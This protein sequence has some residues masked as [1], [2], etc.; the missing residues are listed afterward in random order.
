MKSRRSFIKQASLL[1]AGSFFAPQ[2]LSSCA[3]GVKNI[4]LQ[5]YSLRGMVQQEGIQATLDLV[6]EMGYKN[7]ETAGYGDEKIYGLTPGDFMK[8]V[9]DLGMKVTSA[10]L[11]QAYTKGEEEKVMDWW[12]MATQAHQD[13][14]MSYMIMPWMPVGEKSELDEL[15]RYC[16]YFNQVGEITSDANINFGFH[17]HAG[18]FKKIG[19]HVI[20]DYMLANTDPK[21]VCFQLDVYWCQVGGANPVEY[22]KNYK[23]QILITHIKDEKEIGASGTMD[24]EAIFNQMYKNKIKDWYV[25]VERYTNNDPKASVQESFSYLNAA[26]YVK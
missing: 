11:G 6:A 8:R 16:D 10:H 21:K 9:E 25:E 4:G 24:F 17:N 20:F 14:G 26:E 5:L 3:S 1:T 23:D 15:K 12:K 13:A 18:E 22:L 7:L 19:D 2:L